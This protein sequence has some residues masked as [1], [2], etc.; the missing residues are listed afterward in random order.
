MTITTVSQL[1]ARLATE[2]GPKYVE[3]QANGA[4]YRGTDAQGDSHRLHSAKGPRPFIFLPRAAAELCGKC[5]ETG[6]SLSPWPGA[7]AAWR[8]VVSV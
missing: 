7:Q 6:R 2:L 8:G 4:K 1:L 3:Q 5:L